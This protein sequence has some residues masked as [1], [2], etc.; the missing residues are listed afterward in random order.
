[1][2]GVT[3]NLG[4]Q[5][6]IPGGQGSVAAQVAAG[7]GVNRAAQTYGNEADQGSAGKAPY[8]LLALVGIY[9]LWAWIA[10]NERIRE[11]LNPSNIAANLH[12]IISITLIAVIGLVSL[13]VLT[14]KLAAMGV[15]GASYVAQIVAA[16]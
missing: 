13:K 7:N 12:N 5:V 4:A 15:P 11:S 6:G 2:L 16:A 10:Q 14:T 8:V 3:S 1:M 9:V